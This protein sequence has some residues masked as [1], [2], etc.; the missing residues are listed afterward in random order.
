MYQ[1][2][3]GRIEVSIVTILLNYF[4]KGLIKQVTT[5]S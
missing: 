4:I 2:K 3:S 1:T 5:M